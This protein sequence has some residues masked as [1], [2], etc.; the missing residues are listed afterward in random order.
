MPYRL[1]NL[2]ISFTITFQFATASQPATI[3]LAELYQHGDGFNVEAGTPFFH[4]QEPQ[5]WL[6]LAAVLDRPLIN[7]KTLAEITAQNPYP[8]KE[9]SIASYNEAQVNLALALITLYYIQNGHQLLHK[10]D[11]A[12]LTIT[13][14]VHRNSSG[15][16]QIEQVQTL[17]AAI[18]K[19]TQLADDRVA[20]TCPGFI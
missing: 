17:L 15:L 11:T 10:P 14:Q 5:I 8:L 4:L 3:T 7:G 9:S 16:A 18:L 12:P 6:H 20:A 2:I 19:I 1:I 13:I